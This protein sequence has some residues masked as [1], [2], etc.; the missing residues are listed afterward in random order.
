MPK[1]KIQ[2][3]KGEDRVVFSWTAP[4]YIEHHRGERWYLVAGTITAFAVIVCFFS[5]NWS[6]ALAIATFAAVYYYIRRHHPAKE[7]PIVISEMGIRA[8]I[9]FFPYSHIQKFWIIYENG[10]QT[11]NLRIS[12]RVHSD[13]IIQLN[14]EDPVPLR[15]YL[16][17]QI[18]E[19]E[20]KH[21]RPSDAI[22]RLLKL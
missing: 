14:H 20:G 7:I 5:G 3:K 9:M 13:V 10:L 11:L 12:G 21:E 1:Q 6:F 15:Q 2:E 19:W 16:V 8:G 4:E 22:M 17:G 18:A